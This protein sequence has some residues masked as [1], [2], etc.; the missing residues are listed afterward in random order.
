M[1]IEQ[2]Y[3][4]L[5]EKL[6]E[7]GQ[8]RAVLVDR[9][10]AKAVERKNLEQELIAAGVDVAHPEQEIQRLNEESRKLF[11]EAKAK[12]EQFDGEL[13]VAMGEVLPSTPVQKAAL[14]HP[15][16]LDSLKDKEQWEIPTPLPAIDD[17]DI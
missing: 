17:I 5:V 2:E 13:R 9:E 16:A 7:L 12:V 6:T 3:L 14:E 8:K 11:E 15:A 1:G 10:A 4:G